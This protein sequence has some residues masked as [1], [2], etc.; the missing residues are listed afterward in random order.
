MKSQPSAHQ[1]HIYKVLKIMLI[2]EE[3]L[4]V[5]GLLILD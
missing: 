3:I 2:L 5:H 4:L 1:P